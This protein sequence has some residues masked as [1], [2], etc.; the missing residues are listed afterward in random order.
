MPRDSAPMD[1]HETDTVVIGAGVVGLA[2]AAAVAR[3]GRETIILEKNRAIGAETSS[4]NSEV[5]HAGLYYPTGSLKGRFCVKGRDQLYAWCRARGVPHAQ[6][7][8]LI[9]ATEAA[10]E[11]A[12]EGVLARAHANGVPEL[13]PISGAEARAMEPDLR[14]TAAL[15]SPVTGVVDSHA[16]M[17]SLLG[18]AEDAGAA[19]ALDAPVDRAVVET[20]GISVIT[21]GETPTRLKARRVINAG[22]LWAQAIAAKIEGL[23]ASAVPETIFYKGNYFA[24]ER[25]R[26]PFKRLIYPA[27][28]AGG[29][30]VHLTLDLSGAAK[31]GPDVEPLEI[32][33]A[34]EI[35]YTVDPARGDKFYAAIRKY[36]PGLPDGA[37]RPDYSGVRPKYG[38]DYGTDFRIDGPKTHGVPGLY[39][40][41]GFESPALTASLAIGAHVAELARE[42]VA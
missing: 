27:P 22:G 29:L 37:L 26:A 31:F 25:G 5:I 2:I 12:L 41:F 28:V 33:D 14:A 32:S 11:P 42:Q 3:E 18:D 30:G 35:D 38:H 6:I 36:W 13:R 24:L 8:K 9:V 40:L 16:F 19:L 17:L 15:W 23:P 39:N 10:E 21:G 34:A 4:R 20:D 7:G 1:S